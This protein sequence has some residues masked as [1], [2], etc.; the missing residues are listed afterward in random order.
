[1]HGRQK[2]VDLCDFKA[3]LVTIVIP[4]LYKKKKIKILFIS[5]DFLSYTVLLRI[6]SKQI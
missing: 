6:N 1:M 4:C 3:N 2:W 5:V